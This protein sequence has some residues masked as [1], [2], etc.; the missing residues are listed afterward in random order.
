MFL[1]TREL[2]NYSPE[3]QAFLVLRTISSGHEIYVRFH[4]LRE[5]T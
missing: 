1:Y 3:T 4:V 5:P 2:Q